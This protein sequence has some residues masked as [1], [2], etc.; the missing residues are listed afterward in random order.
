MIIKPDHSKKTHNEDENMLAGSYPLCRIRL[1]CFMVFFL[2]TVVFEGVPLGYAFWPD[3][4]EVKTAGDAIK[5]VNHPDRDA[6]TLRELTE[7]AKNLAIAGNVKQAIDKYTEIINRNPKDPVMYF[8][9]GTLYY[10]RVI[11]RPAQDAPRTISQAVESTASQPQ[12]E[13][14]PAEDPLDGTVALCG[15][16]LNDFDQAITLNPNYA[17][18]FYMRGVLLTV[19]AC[20]HRNLEAAVADFDQA[21][22][23]NPANAAFYQERGSTRGKLKQFDQALKDIDQAILIEPNNYH[24]FYEKGLIL[25]KMG[26]P[27][28]AAENYMWALTFAPPDQM[29]A[30]LS[31]LKTVRNNDP[32]IFMADLNTLIAKRPAISSLYAYRGMLFAD[33]KKWQNAIDDF[34]TALLLQSGDRDLYYSRGKV[35]YAAGKN[36]EALKDF[37]MSCRLNH[38]AACNYIKIMGKEMTLDDRWVPFW[39]SKDNRKYFYDRKHLK[40]QEGNHRV[41]RVRVESNVTGEENPAGPDQTKSGDDQGGYTLEWWEFKCSSSQMRIS[42]LS[43]LN[44][45]DQ[46]TESYPEFEK[47]FRSISP[48]S[49]SGKLVRIACGKSGN[50]AP[51][52]K[53]AS[54]SRQ[55][56][57]IFSP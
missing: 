31:A 10:R 46:V 39:Y 24:F 6:D 48:E 52:R 41:V 23:L 30:F 55:E 56:K 2:S 32:R 57:P 15:L 11:T 16:A 54:A 49:I 36:A 37:Q 25:E 34:S 8:E 14:P 53:P 40:T 43:R 21:L 35:F 38:A 28:E 50:K 45:D 26:K 22:K 27:T 47:H 44:T 1:L 19:E 17:I 7:E 5:P 13:P 42:R 20:P 4:G 12:T 3:S 9:R 33:G 51:R 29:E 18:F